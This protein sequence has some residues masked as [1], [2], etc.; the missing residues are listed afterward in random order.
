VPLVKL[1]TIVTPGLSQLS[2]HRWGTTCLPDD[3]TS[4]ELLS[5]FRRWLKTRFSQNAFTDFSWT[6]SVYILSLVY[7]Q[8][9]LATLEILN[10]LIGWYCSN[11]TAVLFVVLLH[12]RSPISVAAAAIFMASQASEDK[13]SQKGNRHS[14][15]RLLN[16]QACACYSFVLWSEWVSE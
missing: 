7:L 2:T 8:Y 6:A 1:T 4:A 11:Y 13:K 5:S 15:T 16:Q 3:V 14:L 12:R 10:W 9:C